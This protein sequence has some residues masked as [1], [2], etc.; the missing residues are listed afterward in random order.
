MNGMQLLAP[1]GLLAL[2]GI[3]LVIFFHMRHTTPL[4]RPVPTLRFWQQ[5]PLRQPTKRASGAL[6]FHY[7]CSCSSWQSEHSDWRWHAQRSQM[8]GRG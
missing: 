2:L 8:P 5:I 1:L 3:P 4:E 7:C 6:P